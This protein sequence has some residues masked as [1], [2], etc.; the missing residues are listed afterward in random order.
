[1]VEFITGASG[2]GKTMELLERIKE[3]SGKERIVLVPEQ[4]STEFDKKLYYH[5]G[6]KD[7]NSLLSLSFSSLARQLFQIYGEPDR[8]GEYADD[9]ARL[10]LTYQ[11]INEAKNNPEQLLFF[12]RGGSQPGFAEEILKLIGDMKK[13][14]ISPQKL[15]LKADLFEKRLH[16][17]VK[18]TANIFYEYEF[19]MEQYGF[20]DHLEN[21]RE[22]AKAANLNGFFKGTSVFLDEFESFTGDQL[23]MLKIILSSAEIL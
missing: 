7:F 3:C 20:K 10:I 19:L 8:K 5:I 21:I 4:Y 1:M 15:M 2:T 9:M 16:D 23:D 11:A 12:R 13:S 18:D 6:A 14:G 17:K 22:A